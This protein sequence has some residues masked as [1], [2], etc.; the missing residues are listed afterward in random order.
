M[1]AELETSLRTLE[2]DTIDLYQM[3]NVGSLEAYEQVMGPGGALEELVSARE[4]GLIRAIGLTSHSL[5]MAQ[6]AAACGQIDTLMFPFNFIMSH[7][8]EQ[9]LPLCRQHGVTLLAMKPMGGGVFERADVAFGYL[10]QFPDVVKLVG[11]ERAEEIDEI[12]E[13]AAGGF[14]LSADLEAEM[15]RLREELGTNFCRRCGYCLPCPQGIEIPGVLTFESAWRR[16]TPER[17]LR[18]FGP[19]LEK[20]R[21]C[22]ECRQCVERCPYDLAVPELLKEQLALYDQYFPAQT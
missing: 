4:E 5:E 9:L 1:R 13:L 14:A 21:D 16:M 18:M 6:E 2:V 8:A 22:V 17:T 11:I 7:V 19:R 15:A 12:I 20:A 3:H 10:G